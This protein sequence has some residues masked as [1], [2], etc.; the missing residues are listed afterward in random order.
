MKFSEKK[1]MSLEDAE[2]TAESTALRQD[3][4]DV[5]VGLTV[6]L[7]NTDAECRE[8]QMLH[9]RFWMFLDTWMKFRYV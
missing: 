6:S 1:Q 7:Q 9:L 5:S 3:V 8:Q 2:V 4:R